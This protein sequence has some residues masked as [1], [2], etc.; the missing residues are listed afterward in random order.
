MFYVFVFQIDGLPSVFDPKILEGLYS[1]FLYV[2]PVGHLS[3]LW[4]AGPDDLL[5]GVCHVQ[6]D[7]LDLASDK[8]RE[9]EQPI[10]NGAGLGALE[11]PYQGSFLALGGFI[12]DN[13]IEFPL[14]QGSFVYRKIRAN[15]LRIQ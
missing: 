10:D 15:V 13:C 7:F 8:K 6:C 5:H 4:E 11:Y 14:G 9:F 1:E 3:G 2:E 12:G